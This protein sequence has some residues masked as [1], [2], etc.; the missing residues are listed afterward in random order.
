LRFGAK[1][2]LSITLAA[3]IPTLIFLLLSYDLISRSIEKWADERVE[4]ALIESSRAI[5]EIEAFHANQMSD[6]VKRI[7]MDVELADALEAGK[8][9]GDIVSSHAPDEILAVYDR[10][11]RLLFS[12]LPDITPK[13]ITDF[14]PSVE[15]LSFEPTTSD[16]PMVDGE[17]FACAMPILSEDGRRRLGAAVVFRK[18]PFARRRVEEG[19]RLYQAQASG[20]SPAIRT[21]LITLSLA[22]ILIF[23]ISITASSLMMRSVKRS[24]RRLMAGIDEIGKGNLDY[25]VRVNSK[26]EFAELAG[27]FNRMAEQIKR[28]REEIKRAEKMAAWR[29]VAQKL[30]HEIKN[31]LTPIQLSAQRLRRRYRSGDREGFEELLDRCVDTIIREVEGVKRLL[32]EFSQLAR[33]PPPKMEPISPAEAVEAALNLFDEMPEGIKVETDLDRSVKVT[34][35]FDQIKRAIFNLIKNA[36]EAM[37]G[38]GVIRISVRAEGEGAKIEISDTGP[39]IPDEMRDLLFVPHLSTKP[40]GMGLGLAIVKKSIDDHGW[41]IDV[42]DN[43]R[44]RGT[45]FIIT[46]PNRTH[47]ESPATSPL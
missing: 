22:A 14:L 3:L 21:V 42:R 31:P 43:P 34:G 19:K 37:K 12:S 30:A 15:D 23:T 26:D 20:R 28:S 8:S 39:G 11:G 41:R 40:G 17:L 10:S 1:L 18:L 16:I 5:M 45:S 4:R 24:L 33:M 46:I 35:D 6:L 25:R 29:E 36:V 32:D 2:T 7:A 44:G 47:T 13:R 9:V 38:T 27:A